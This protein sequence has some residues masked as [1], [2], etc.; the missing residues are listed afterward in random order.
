[1]LKTFFVNGYR[2][3]VVTNQQGVG[4]GL[5]EL[6]ELEH[7]HDTM[8]AAV[9]RQGA[10]IDGVFYCPH[11]ESEGCD[12]RK[13]KPGLVY[14]AIGAL[15]CG[16]DLARSWLVGDSPRDI[17]AG[18]AAGLRTLLVGRPLEQTPSGLS[19]PYPP[20]TCTVNKIDD[21]ATT[22]LRHEDANQ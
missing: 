16:V 21:V 17:Q 13:P 2:L 22:I 1:M 20:P 14:R 5:I 6:N 10:Q 4:K 12:C 15:G 11:L 7:I 18:H 9:A 8:C 19:P 3:V